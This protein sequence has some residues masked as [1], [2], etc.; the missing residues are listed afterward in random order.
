MLLQVSLLHESRCL[1][2]LST[3]LGPRDGSLVCLKDG[4]TYSLRTGRR[5]PS[6]WDV[7]NV[8]AARSGERQQITNPDRAMGLGLSWSHTSKNVKKHTH[9]D[10]RASTHAPSHVVKHNV[11]LSKHPPRPS[12]A[13]SEAKLIRAATLSHSHR[14]LRPSAP[15]P[16][17]PTS[18]STKH[19]RVFS[20]FKSA[21]C[22]CGTV[23]SAALLP[24]AAL[25]I[26]W[27]E[28]R[29]CW[30]ALARRW[31]VILDQHFHNGGELRAQ[32][33]KSPIYDLEI[34]LEPPR[35]SPSPPSRLFFHVLSFLSSSNCV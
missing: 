12:V 18:T 26:Y 4:Q 35:P 15:R 5:A 30:R 14:F 7:R 17:F 19:R 9:G 16:L 2:H 33:N 25:C 3:I 13:D 10:G 28:R 32:K 23:I 24:P 22:L 1:R 29:C 34:P 8:W 6:L 21:I 11:S 20:T 27:K 31:D